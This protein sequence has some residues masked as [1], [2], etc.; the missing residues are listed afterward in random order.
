MFGAV[1][2]PT[3]YWLVRSTV[4]AFAHVD[5][6]SF[7]HRALLIA[8]IL[9]LWPLLRL[10]RVRRLRDLE[11][12]PNDHWLRHLVA[13]VLIAAIPLLL[14]SA[15]I[16][17]L[18]I[19]SLRRSLDWS[20]LV[21]VLGAAIAAPAIEE[22]FFRGLILGILL[23]SSRTILA[24]FLTSALFSILHFLKAPEHTSLN[25]TWTSGF[26]SIAQAFSQFGDP[27]LV[28]AGF[29]TLFLIGWIL[30]DARVLTRSLWLSA[31]LHAGW[32]AA[33]GIVSK[34]T[35]REFLAL[36]WLGKN[37]LVGLVPLAVGLL[38]WLLLRLWIKH[39]RPAR[40]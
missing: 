32:I 14:C 9:L 37:L 29:T 16:V 8:A 18:H 17:S 7:F 28:A 20:R 2:A 3:L 22:A 35:R 1:L 30:A 40:A 15:G 26:N 39:D 38:T 33:A 11:L 27:M 31:G 5:F 24:M 6:E 4:P 23:R 10:L 25:V 13:G 12:E 19:Y 34:I 36:P 21:A